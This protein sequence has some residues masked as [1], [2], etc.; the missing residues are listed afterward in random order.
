[1]KQLFAMLLM[2]A[3]FTTAKAQFSF[4][5]SA[6]PNYS[7]AKYHDIPNAQTTARWG[8]FVGFAPAFKFNRLLSV[9]LESQLSTKGHFLNNVTPHYENR[10]TYIDIIP[11]VAVQVVKHVEI[12]LGV[13]YGL[14]LGEEQRV[15]EGRWHSTK[16]VGITKPYDLGATAKVKVSWNN[17]YGVVRYNHGLMNVSDITYTDETGQTVSGAGFSNT[18]LQFGLGYT[19]RW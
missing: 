5:V 3:A 18:N 17:F 7:S 11:E 13:N 19:L 6:G 10:Y 2:F 16:P 9:S 14:R 1:M 4:N 8:Y 15:D 12:G